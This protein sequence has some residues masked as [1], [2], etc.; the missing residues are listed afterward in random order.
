MLRESARS[1]RVVNDFP[2]TR[3]SA[4]TRRFFKSLL[5]VL[6]WIWFVLILVIVV[7]VTMRYVFGEGRI[8]FEEIQWHLYAVGFLIG[9]ATCMDSNNHVRVDIFP[10]ANGFALAGLDRVVWTVAFVLSVRHRDVDF[11][12]PLRFL[13]LHDRGDIGFAGRSSVSVDHQEFSALEYVVA[14]GRRG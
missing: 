1:F 7:N 6:S 4:A 13:F 9:L 5:R 10:R 12:Y 11:F 3:L 2:H 14:T 8:E